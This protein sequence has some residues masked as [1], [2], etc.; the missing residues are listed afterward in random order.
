MEK[1]QEREKTK[2]ENAAKAFA[3]QIQKRT[4]LATS[5]LLE[6]L[7]SPEVPDVP[8]FIVDIAKT[9]LKELESI[10]TEAE[11]MSADPSSTPNFTTISTAKDLGPIIAAAKK[12][13][14]ALEMF[15]EQV[16]KA[17]RSQ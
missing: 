17:R 15:C 11:A 2:N 5:K 3:S 16:R 12:S 1:I 10:N 7:A 8:A 4:E 14:V 13:T 9:Q 6:A